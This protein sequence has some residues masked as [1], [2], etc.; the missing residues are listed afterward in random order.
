[1]I[2]FEGFVIG[3]EVIDGG[4]NKMKFLKLV[5]KYGINWSYFVDVLI[6]DLFKIRYLRYIC[7]LRFMIKKIMLS[8]KDILK[9]R[10][11]NC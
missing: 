9:V 1:M 5:E 6:K 3:L 11:N 8:W 2:I 7:F 4:N 10:W